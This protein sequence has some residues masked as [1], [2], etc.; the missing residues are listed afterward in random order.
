MAQKSLG[1]WPVFSLLDQNFIAKVKIACVFGGAGN[2]AIV[3]TED[4]EVYSLGSNC[5]NCLGE[6]QKGGPHSKFSLRILQLP[7]TSI[8]YATLHGVR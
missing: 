8:N 4:D 7:L 5:S 3:V 1:R 2:E 6:I